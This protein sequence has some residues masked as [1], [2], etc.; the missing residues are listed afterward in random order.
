[1]VFLL[2]SLCELF[3][4]SMVAG[5]CYDWK[6]QNDPQANDIILDQ[7]RFTAQWNFKSTKTWAIDPDSFDQ[8]GCIHTAQGLEFD[9]VGVIIGRDLVYRKGQVCTDASQRAKSDYS[10]KGLSPNDPKCDRI[11]R[12]TYRTLMT[13]GQKGCFVYCEDIGLNKHIKRF[14]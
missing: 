1:M 14:V 7:G 2:F 10:L 4:L 12:N 13:R 8:I 9:Y 5:Y 11:I 6:S 3:I